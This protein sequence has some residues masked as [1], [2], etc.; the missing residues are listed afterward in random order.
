MRLGAAVQFDVVFAI[1]NL[2]R[3]LRLNQILR[4]YRIN[5]ICA[6]NTPLQKF[7]R[8]QVYRHQPVLAPI[9]RRKFRAFNG[10]SAAVRRKFTAKSVNCCSE[11]FLLLNPICKMGTSAAAIGKHVRRGRPRRHATN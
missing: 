9:G 8:I 1:A 7:L 4:I 5:H 6:G 10:R 2:G 11:R 3:A